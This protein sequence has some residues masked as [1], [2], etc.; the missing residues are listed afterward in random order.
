MS[1]GGIRSKDE[2]TGCYILDFEATVFLALCCWPSL[3]SP[4]T[5]TR[6]TW[7]ETQNKATDGLQWETQNLATDDLPWETQYQEVHLKDY[8]KFSR[9]AHQMLLGWRPLDVA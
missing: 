5:W 3:S 2:V 8:G 9:R 7:W 4:T 6:P 1:G